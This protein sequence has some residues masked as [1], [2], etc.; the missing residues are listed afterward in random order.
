MKRQEFIAARLRRARDESGLSQTELGKLYGCTGAAVSQMERGV[1]G[2]GME[3]LEKMARIFN[4]PLEWFF[5]DEVEAPNLPQKPIELM[6][7]EV[8]ERFNRL[9]LMEVPIRG[10]VPAG[11]PFPV[12][13]NLE[14]YVEIPKALLKDAANSEGLFALRVS[15][16]S[17]IGDDIHSRDIVVIEPTTEIVDGKIYVL[18][19]A[20]ECVARHVYKLNNSLRLVSSN[21]DYA[22]MEVDNVE[23]LGRV[24]LA[25]SW[26][27]Y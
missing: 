18:R 22:E 23:I 13:E 8:H 12:E 6:L 10:S 3:P 16:D 21:G 2:V 24:I 4:K 11:C 5:S 20:N 9:E 25:G 7:R 17:L 1:R 26:K 27:K 14:G 19:L 15:G